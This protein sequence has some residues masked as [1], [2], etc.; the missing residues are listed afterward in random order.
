MPDNAL[1]NSSIIASP[2]ILQEEGVRE[3]KLEEKNDGDQRE[4]EMVKP[5]VYPD[6][7]GEPDC[8][9][10]LRTGMCRYGRNCRF[11][12]PAD[13]AKVA[14]SD[15][16]LPQRVGQ[17]DCGFYLK[18]GTC[19]Y[20]CTCKY[21]HPRDKRN[22]AQVA[23]NNLGLPLRQEEKCCPYYMRTFTCKFGVACKFHHPQPSS[24]PTSMQTTFTIPKPADIGSLGSS[25]L[26]STGLAYVGGL[27]TWLLSKTQYVSDPRDVGAQTYMPFLFSPSQGIMPA[28]GWNSYMGNLNPTPT[29]LNLVAPTSIFGN[30]LVYNAND[31][32]GPGINNPVNSLVANIPLL[33]QR[34]DQA[35]CRYFMSTGSC[36]YGADCKYH[37]PI[38]RSAQF[39][40]NSLGPHGLPVRRGEATCSNFSMYG[41]CKYG[42]TCKFNHPISCYLPNFSLGMPY[43][44]VVDHQ[45]SSF[46]YPRNYLNIDASETSA[47]KSRITNWIQK[48]DIGDVK[49][50]NHSSDVKSPEETQEQAGNQS[51]YLQASPELPHN[52]SD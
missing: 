9:Y 36:K 48:H 27:P 38:E 41:S 21:H 5:A 8:L 44:S 43:V 40:I 31:Q 49:N 11:N 29:S 24:I 39:A 33:P 47:S 50:Q 46:P 13:P 20:G 15:G 4:R 23:L 2:D 42:S 26:P 37:H 19:K 35:D 7:P 34:P 6:R 51:H 52:Q 16:E 10:Y 32:S 25:I 12:H 45:Y 28:Q 1:C 18:T 14:K 22:V 30:N 3:M 17:P